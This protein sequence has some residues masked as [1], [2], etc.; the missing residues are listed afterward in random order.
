MCDK[1]PSSDYVVALSK[2]FYPEDTDNVAI[3][4]SNHLIYTL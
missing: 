3:I 1:L 2:E 4:L